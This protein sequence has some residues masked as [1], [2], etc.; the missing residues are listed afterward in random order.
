MIAFAKLLLTSLKLFHCFRLLPGNFCLLILLFV[1]FSPEV[2]VADYLKDVLR[3]L[4]HL[5]LGIKSFFKIGVG[6][7]GW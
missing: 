6:S 1:L 7:I 3:C 2:K 4:N 5:F